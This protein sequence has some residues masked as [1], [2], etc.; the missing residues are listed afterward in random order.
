MSS[1]GKRRIGDGFKGWL[2]TLVVIA[3]LFAA[4][5]GGLYLYLDYLLDQRHREGF[6]Q[7]DLVTP[8]GEDRN[9]MEET[10]PVY[11]RGG[12]A[13]KYSCRLSWPVDS[14][15]SAL[16][17][18]EGFGAMF[19]FQLENTG[20]V[21]IYAESVKVNTSWGQLTKRSIG[22]YVPAGERKHLCYMHLPIPEPA[23]ENQSTYE[24]RLDILV[25]ASLAWVRV[26][27]V[28][29]E[30][31]PIN[32][33]ELK[34]PE[35]YPELEVNHYY[36][37]DKIVPKIR[38]DQE[39]LK[40]ILSNNSLPVDEDITIQDLVDGFDFVRDNLEY[41]EDQNGDE[42]YSPCETLERGGG[43]CEDWSMLYSG[44]VSAMG[45][46]TRVIV[47]EGH[48][49]SAVYIGKSGIILND[50]EDRFATDIP[51]LILEDDL[52]LWL[53]VE[54]QSKL[55]FG[56]PPIDVVPTDTSNENMYVYGDGDLGWVPDDSETISIVDIYL[57]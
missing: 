5:A 19:N 54:P 7:D 9:Y 57:S 46:S 36:V 39:R 25:E 15:G 14:E 47:T 2:I 41:M 42:W 4:G 6:S 37:Y 28:Q 49:F 56:W 40:E 8:L 17:G 29:F 10:P 35:A 33:L 53:I 21:D 44:L 16:E 24:V 12:M 3:I 27:D 34:T 45:G 30:T 1:K 55:S 31:S 50:I 23:P 26:K 51:F 13:P 38:G 32:I 20:E 48:A 52:G 11:V 43:D 18:Y 22:K